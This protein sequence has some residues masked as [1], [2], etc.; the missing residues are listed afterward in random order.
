VDRETRILQLS[1]ERFPV[2]GGVSSLIPALLPE[3]SRNN[4][5]VDLVTKA[6]YQ[7][8]FGS[9][10]WRGSR[11][12]GIC[13]TDAEGLLTEAEFK[14]Q[15]L[16]RR[17]IAQL[18]D[19]GQGFDLINAH[20]A[21]P[22]SVA[23]AIKSVLGVPLVVSLH[24]LHSVLREHSLVNGE[25]DLM[26]N[27]SAVALEKEA[28][29]V[30][31]RFLVASD[32]MRKLAISDYGVEPSL[33]KVIPYGIDVNAYALSP[34][35][36]RR[37]RVQLSRGWA[38][39][40]LFAGR[41][42]PQKG[43]E[44]LIE[45]FS[46]IAA[47][48]SDVQLV[49]VGDGY[50]RPRILKRAVAFGSRCTVMGKIHPMQLRGYLSA[51]DVVVVPSIFEPFG[52]IAIEGMAAGAAMI[53]A[54]TGGLAEIGRDRENCLFARVACTKDGDRRIDH[55]ELSELIQLVLYDRDLALKLRR[56][57]RAR[58]VAEYDSKT[59][60]ERMA[61]YYRRIVEEAKGDCTISNNPHL[62]QV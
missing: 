39:T 15:V 12:H 17:K 58:A 31:D 19:C 44:T 62:Q 25:M 27:T 60:G 7:R 43:I 32:Y 40:I 49:L 18:T 2:I 35:K 1:Y 8:D 11:I 13:S 9:R 48:T 24:I 5:R 51:A 21:L 38:K 50:L 54:E 57:G 37:L 6:E 33:V 56:G 26:K 23:S 4:C 46:D 34:A 59:W 47:R 52:M 10:E 29:R 61:S 16:F 3:L 41:F 20:D 53:L 45:A 42:V 14:T 55:V 22:I 30:G 28:A 36:V